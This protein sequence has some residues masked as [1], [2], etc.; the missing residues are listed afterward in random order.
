[1][2]SCSLRTELMRIAIIGAGIGGLTAALALRQFGFEPQVFEQAPALL[3]VGAAILIWPNAMRVLHQLGLADAVRQHGGIME[4]ARWLNYDGR[5]LN[6]FRFP[7]T[8][9][10][11]MALHRAELQHVLLNALSENSI[12]LDHVFESYEQR[13]G[14]IVARFAGGRS[15]ECDTLIGADGLHSRA[16]AQLLN[17]GPPA[18]HAYVAWRGV[19]DSVPRSITPGIAYEIYGSGQ[20][21]GIGTLGSNKIGWWASINKDLR[22]PNESKTGNEHDGHELYRDELLRSFAGWW[23]P[24]PELIRATPVSALIRNVT[25]DRPPVRKWGEG[26]MILLGD[27]IHPITPNLGQGGCLAIE[28]AAI[29]AR[30]LDK[31]GTAN[32][33]EGANSV[34]DALRKFESMRFARTAT[35]RRY[36]RIYGVVG[37]WENSLAVVLRRLALSSVPAKLTKRVLRSLFDYD[38]YAVSI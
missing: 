35:I 21:F 13:D 11:P 26:P 6:N 15:F 22:D 31:Y 5:L 9:L 33:P 1:L 30:C 36:S 18:E 12:H 29:L 34:P 17:D 19:V 10:P 3:D 4:Q 24:V 23:A 8:D 38:A 25:C 16:R 7:K 37:Q 2:D 28:D 20:R 32:K 14:E 27:A